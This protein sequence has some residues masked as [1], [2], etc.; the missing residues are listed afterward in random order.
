MKSC[1]PCCLGPLSLSLSVL[2]R[3]GADTGRALLALS[4]NVATPASSS[5]V[6]GL[7]VD[8]GDILKF[9]RR[10]Q[11]FLTQENPPS[12]AL[13]VG[14]PHFDLTFTRDHAISAEVRLSPDLRAEWHVYRFSPSRTEV[15]AFTQT[16]EVILVSAPLPT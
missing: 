7:V 8:Y 5:E 4:A 16:L 1:S 11:V 14:L 6:E 9:Q 10:L 13:R 3:G 12:L 15:R 2:R